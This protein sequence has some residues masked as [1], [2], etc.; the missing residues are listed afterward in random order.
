MNR[1]ESEIVAF[2]E[3]YDWA[4]GD[5]D[6]SPSDDQRTWQ[7]VA[8]DA[9]HDLCYANDTCGENFRE[10]I[11]TTF[12]NLGP[13]SFKGQDFKTVC[14]HKQ[15]GDPVFQRQ[16][17]PVRGSLPAYLTRAVTVESMAQYI[18][19]LVERRG[20]ATVSKEQIENRLIESVDTLGWLCLTDATGRRFTDVPVTL[21]YPDS[22]RVFATF[23]PDDEN[24]PDT[25]SP[26]FWEEV[27]E[28]VESSNGDQTH[29]HIAANRLA[30]DPDPNKN[31]RYLLLYYDHSS[32][33]PCRYPT[34]PDAEFF[35]YF[36]PVD[37]NQ[38]DYGWTC[39]PTDGEDECNEDLAVPEVVHSN[40]PMDAGHVWIRSL[41]PIFS[42]ND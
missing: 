32:A 3:W 8:G 22:E 37:P 16:G 38:H 14:R 28:L 12:E 9:R 4:M 35:P 11:G 2:D 24:V 5:H 1:C 18:Q 30:L 7:R 17:K 23:T 19:M 27:D 10:E 20:Q 26:Q 29:A 40:P 36:R 33:G 34:P 39:P 21:A 41:G 13:A 42:A 15:N 31:R 25:H 6:Q